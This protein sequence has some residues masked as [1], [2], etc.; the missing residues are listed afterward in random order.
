MNFKKEDHEV[1]ILFRN[2][3]ANLDVG[4]QSHL[5]EG[6]AKELEKKKKS[7]RLLAFGWFT[8]MLVLFTFIS[9]GFILA[10]K[11]RF[12]SESQKGNSETKS[13]Q[14]MK[15]STASMEELNTSEAELITNGESPSTNSNNE[16]LYIVDNERI[17]LIKNK[18]N[19]QNSRKQNSHTISNN[20][21]TEKSSSILKSCN[22]VLEAYE[23]DH[24]KQVS[25]EQ[26]YNQPAAGVMDQG[27]FVQFLN[28]KPSLLVKT[29]VKANKRAKRE[30]KDD[31]FS[32]NFSP[33]S[34]VDIDVYYSPEVSMRTIK[35]STEAALAYAQKRAGSESFTGSSS[36]GFRLSYITRQ[37]FGIRT[38]INY[39]KIKEQFEY[40]SGIDTSRTIHYDANRVPIDTSYSYNPRVNTKYNSYKFLDIPVIIGYEVDLTDFVFSFNAGIGFNLS[41]RQSGQIYSSNLSKV[42]EIASAKDEISGTKYFKENVGISVLGS[43]GLNYKINR[44][45]MLL[46]EPTVRYYLK[47]ITS[48]VYPLSQKYLQ[49]G[50]VTGLRYR[51]Y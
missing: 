40:F 23:D 37:G 32:K 7:S 35:A 4:P 2:K 36:V 15:L 11:W 8:K 34:H 22:Q 38:G 48:D 26:I 39:S 21:I 5:W 16:N 3:L 30:L 12:G 41:S 33:L 19:L 43:F 25:A 17:N 29:N 45:L 27:N 20:L 51:I 13:V 10:Y 50:I 14:A 1:D 18:S 42:I 46:A 28:L 49:L 31:C 6:I 24:L 9:F 44:K 47:P